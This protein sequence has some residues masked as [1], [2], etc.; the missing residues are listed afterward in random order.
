MADIE[1]STVKSIGD[2]VVAK[3]IDKL[4]ALA[5]ELQ[6]KVDEANRRMWM[7]IFTLLMVAGLI[8]AA[9]SIALFFLQHSSQLVI[10]I[11]VAYAVVLSASEYFFIQRF[12]EKM[13]RDTRALY[14]IVD[15]LREIEGSI[16]KESNLSTLERAEFRIRLSRFC[17][18]S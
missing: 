7:R 17:A 16:A 14:A 13:H 15:M 12:R 5:E 10:M 2:V 6:E 18:V 9:C 8:V 11:G 1:S 4:L 3:D